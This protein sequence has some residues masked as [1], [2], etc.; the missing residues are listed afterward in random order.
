[1]QVGEHP[2]VFEEVDEPGDEAIATQVGDRDPGGFGGVVTGTDGPVGVEDRD[3][4][5]EDD[6][7]LS[8]VEAFDP[9]EELVDDDIETRLFGDF[10]HD[11]DFDRFA[12]RDVPAR[13]GPLPR[14][15][16]VTAA[17]EEQLVVAH[18]DGADGELRSAHWSDARSD[19]CMMRARAVK[20]C[21]S[22]KFFAAR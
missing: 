3:P 8:V 19:L 7:V 21:S 13:H 17:D 16:A 5:V 14:R 12:D 15:G 10:A 9:S 1:M 4:E 6:E 22:K 2:D 11:G 18:R 20:P